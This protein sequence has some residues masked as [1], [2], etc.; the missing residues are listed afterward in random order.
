MAGTTTSFGTSG[1][2]GVATDETNELIASNKVEGT[3]V[4][5]RQG[6][7][8]GEA[9]NFMVNKRSGQV[10]YAVLSFGG[11]LRMGE[12]YHPIPWEALD[13]DTQQGGYVVDLDRDK[14]EGAPSYRAD[15]E[16]NFDRA[17]GQQVNDFYGSLRASKLRS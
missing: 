8:L 6:E 16:P 4:Y 9:Y 17:Y 15:Q 2:S 10:Q 14:L 12:S 11:F 5:N 1:Q 13:Y 3:A 7:H